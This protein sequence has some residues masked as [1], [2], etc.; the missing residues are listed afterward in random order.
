LLKVDPVN[1][2]VNSI[3][4]PEDGDVNSFIVRLYN[5]TSQ[6]LSGMVNLVSEIKSVKEV[7]LEEIAMKELEVTDHNRFAINIE[8]KKIKT[9]RITI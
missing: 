7:S 8:P 3:K 5:P 4:K 6:S 2:V 1:V 9:Y